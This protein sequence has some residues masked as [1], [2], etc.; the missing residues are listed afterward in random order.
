MNR[1]V[2]FN[3]LA[4]ILTQL[5]DEEQVVLVENGDYLKRIAGKLAVRAARN[6]FF[7]PLS[8]QDV[9]AG[10]AETANKWRKLAAELGY[11]GPVAW[12]VRA[13]FT[14]KV[15]A[16]KAGPC[17]K[18]FGDP[19][20][21]SLKNDEPTANSLVFWVPRLVPKSMGKSVDEQ[22]SILGDLQERFGLPAYHLSN[23]GSAALLAGLIFS[24]FKRTG[25]RT[26]LKKLWARTNT[27]GSYRGCCGCL[28]LGDF[29]E[30][31]LSSGDDFFWGVGGYSGLGCFPL[32]VE[33]GS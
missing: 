14:L 30:G 3:A 23:Y 18:N 12:R 13:G 29:G 32:G 1:K 33:L 6:R 21:W 28:S 19:Q 15:H 5:S 2:S 8:D 9:P 10:L 25:E 20:Y 4:A 27:L 22:M 24:H 26:P 11:T 31:G 17:Y 7:V 16:P